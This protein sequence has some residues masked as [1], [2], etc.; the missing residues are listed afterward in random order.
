V[1][2]IN[3]EISKLAGKPRC[4]NQKFSR[5][6]KEMRAM[7]ASSPALV[8]PGAYRSDRDF[9][10]DADEECCPP[11]SGKVSLS[12]TL[13]TSENRVAKDGTLRGISTE[14][15]NR[16]PN[17]LGPGQYSKVDPEP[18]RQV[19]AAYSMRGGRPSKADDEARS[20]AA[21]RPGPGAYNTWSALTETGRERYELEKRLPRHCKQSHHASAFGTIFASMKGKK[22]TESAPGN[23]HAPKR[24][25]TQQEVLVHC[26]TFGR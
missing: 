21:P 10:L 5:A 7:S 22:G 4:R 25:V 23:W 3:A 9:P 11:V 14:A 12:T 26:S 18:S 19:A 6:S 24:P 13:K 1:L 20:R 17:P 16:V 2:S 8:G 15:G